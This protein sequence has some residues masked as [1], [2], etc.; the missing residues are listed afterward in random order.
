VCASLNT[1]AGFVPQDGST[2]TPGSGKYSRERAP[3]RVEL[4]RLRV[5][6][7]RQPGRRARGQAEAHPCGASDITPRAARVSLRELTARATLRAQVEVRLVNEEYK[8][9][10]KNTPFLYDLVVT[11]ALEWP[12]L[13]V[14]WLPVRPATRP[15]LATSTARATGCGR[16][17]DPTT[18]G[19]C[20]GDEWTW[21]RHAHL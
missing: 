19:E 17:V 16:W 14:Q 4:S 20:R 6:A 13:T 15:L 5:T 7:R 18:R 21:R 8:I 11:H 3:E 9:W 2:Y 10:K 12:S 1:G